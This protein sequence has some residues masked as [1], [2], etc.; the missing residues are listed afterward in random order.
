[1]KR[2]TIYIFINGI[3][4]RP[5]DE[6][7]WNDKAVT[8]TNKWFLQDCRAGEKY[9][10]FTWATT[11][12]FKQQMRAIKLAKMISFYPEIEDF[13]IVLVGH[14][15]GCDIILRT[16]KLIWGR[17]IKA[18]H[19]FAP[20]C[21]SDLYR[22]GLYDRVAL[23]KQIETIRIYIGGKDEAMKLA[24]LSQLIFGIFGLGYGNLG[25]VDPKSIRKVLGDHSVI[26]QPNYGHST[27]FNDDNF[28]TTMKF[29]TGS[30]L[31]NPRGLDELSK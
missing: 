23:T 12:L 5:G 25:G 17:K 22:N 8:W 16:L 29:I 6:N 13:D 1:M 24:K 11:R 4:T 18:L 3:L 19:F 31:I 26:F 30:P 14:S 20:A 10:Y 7:G 9:E 21:D 28:D 15:N 27:W 2:K